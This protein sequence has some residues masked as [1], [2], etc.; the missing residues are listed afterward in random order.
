MRLRG[1]A[2]SSR[3]LTSPAPGLINRSDVVYSF[4]Q[5]DFDQQIQGA[6]HTSGSTT[7]KSSARST[8][9]SA[10]STDSKVRVA[11]RPLRADQPQ[12]SPLRVD[13]VDV[14]R[15]D[16]EPQIQSARHCAE[17]VT[18]RST[19]VKSFARRRA[20]RSSCRLRVRVICAARLLINRREVL[21][22]S[23]NSTL[24]G[25]I[26]SSRFKERVV[27]V[28]FVLIIRREALCSTS[29]SGLKVPG[30]YVGSV[31]TSPEKSS[32]RRRIRRR[33]AR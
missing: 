26:S 8:S 9:A 32:T 1:S 21:C 33:A 23:T 29:G 6:S 22:A 4:V 27:C 17:F 15:R 2:I 13:E 28:G 12:R 30:A 19:A 11:L 24:C 16:F 31:S 10:I 3:R 14:V 18:W 25:A 20:A 7:V 5:R